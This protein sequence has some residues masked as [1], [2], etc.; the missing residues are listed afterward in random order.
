V[1][2][3]A[4]AAVDSGQDAGVDTGVDSGV[5]AGFDAGVDTGVD[6]GHDAGPPCASKSTVGLDGIAV[7]LAV[8]GA[9][10]VTTATGCGSR[11]TPCGDL[12]SAAYVLT[13]ASGRSVIFVG[14]GTYPSVGTVALPDG[15][16]VS[17][18]WTVAGET[19]TASCDPSA[20][21]TLPSSGTPIVTVGVPTPSAGQVLLDTLNFTSSAAP[22]AGESVY[23]IFAVGSSGSSLVLNDVSVVVPA[24]GTGATGGMGGIGATGASGGCPSQAGGGVGSIGAAGPEG[25]YSALGYTPA[26]TGAAAAGGQ[27]Q[28]GTVPPLVAPNC[29][30][31]EVYTSCA[32]G[33]AGLCFL[34]DMETVCSG[35]PAS[36][37][38][39][40]GGFG[41]TTG[42]G[43]G[44]SVALFLWNEA[45]TL[46]GGS[47]TSG[48]GGRGGVG[49]PG[50][51]G[52]AGGSGASGTT[53]SQGRYD[54]ECSGRNTC[55][56]TFAYVDPPSGTKGDTGGTGGQGGGGAGG[57]SYA[58]Y[59]GGSSTV[60]VPDAAMT[61]T[62]V[63]GT[64]GLGG[65]PNGNTGTA[66]P[67]N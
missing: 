24:G 37:C 52:G 29:T 57:D 5:D 4:E 43:G 16:R 38:G 59:A 34:G 22:T 18:G 9:T 66:L 12:A 61:T 23:G 27:G 33:T 63:P 3:K 14:S 58:Y 46:N 21:P 32:P 13:H 48:N 2:A 6:S 60:T 26:A 19:W 39:G 40:L 62:L 7:F 55:T 8:G 42:G 47:L 25:S 20:T 28:V 51:P 17:G 10:G 54:T 31:A 56:P 53:V 1:D 36:G 11:G 44:S 15:S 64:A 45:V 35:S 65:S 50:G 67:H 49:G 41:G 30:A